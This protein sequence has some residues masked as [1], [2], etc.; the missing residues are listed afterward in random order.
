MSINLPQ[1]IGRP[2]PYA[3]PN[4]TT[5]VNINNNPYSGNSSKNTQQTNQ[6]SNIP[7]THSMMQSSSQQQSNKPSSNPVHRLYEALTKQCM[8]CGVRFS[9]QKQLGEHLDVHQRKNQFFR[10]NK[11]LSRK[12]YSGEDEWIKLRDNDETEAIQC[13]GAIIF[14]D[15]ES[16]N[17]QSLTKTASTTALSAVDFFAT[18]NTNKSKPKDVNEGSGEIVADTE[19]DT[20]PVCHEELEKFY[21]SE[22][23]EWMLKGAVY[24]ESC[25]LYVHQNC[26]SSSHKRKSDGDA[27]G[28][29]KKVKQEF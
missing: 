17:P 20:C 2:N 21:N 15:S 1:Q 12:W 5:S 14:G 3:P 25:N 11:D 4:Q 9:S 23:A 19:Q 16:F 6:F 26:L 13:P 10:N 18:F 7:S 28:F 24:D 22:T 27:G 29:N 8:N